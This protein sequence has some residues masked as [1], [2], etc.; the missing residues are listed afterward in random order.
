MASFPGST[1]RSATIGG[2]LIGMRKSVSGL[3]YA[4]GV[5]VESWPDDG[6]GE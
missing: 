3:V 5:R 4:E 1:C 6:S 2:L